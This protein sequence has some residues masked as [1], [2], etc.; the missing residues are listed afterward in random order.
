MEGGRGEDS[1]QICGLRLVVEEYFQNGLEPLLFE[2]HIH[3]ATNIGSR[4]L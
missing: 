2:L 1:M 3:H 4:E